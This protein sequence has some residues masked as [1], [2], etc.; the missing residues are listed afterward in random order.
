MGVGISGCKLL[1]IDWIYNTDL[2]NSTGNYIPYPV[3]NHNGKE[4]EKE[5]VYI[6]IYIKLNHVAVEQNLTEHYKSTILQ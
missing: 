5:Y 3:I 4:N 1:Y 2:V 6:Y